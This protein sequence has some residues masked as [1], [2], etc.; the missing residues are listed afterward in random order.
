MITLS[1][2][3]DTESYRFWCSAWFVKVLAILDQKKSLQYIISIR[4]DYALQIGYCN[5][6]LC[7]INSLVSKPYNTFW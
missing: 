6:R 3:W 2:F 7:I 1:R 4:N 5:H